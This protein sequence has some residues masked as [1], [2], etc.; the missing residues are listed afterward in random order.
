MPNAAADD[1][2]GEEVAVV[3]ED[4]GNGMEGIQA[5]Q[6]A[7]VDMVDYAGDGGADVAV[8]AVLQNTSAV[9]GAAGDGEIEGDRSLGHWAIDCDPLLVEVVG[10]VT[11]P[12]QDGD[13]G[14]N[15]H[16]ERACS[17]V[18]AEELESVSGVY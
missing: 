8:V 4:I 3:A 5:H 7:R 18:C 2:Y 1:V 6:I 16:V 17:M 15:L 14:L 13:D 9:V 11:N 10:L 12:G